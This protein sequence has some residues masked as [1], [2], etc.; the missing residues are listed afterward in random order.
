[1]SKEK[2]GD[3]AIPIPIKCMVSRK[4]MFELVL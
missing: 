4:V 1:M 3:V 2:E